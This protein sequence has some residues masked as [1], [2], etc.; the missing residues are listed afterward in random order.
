MTVYHVRHDYHGHKFKF[1]EKFRNLKYFHKFWIVEIAPRDVKVNVK[2]E[3]LG[4]CIPHFSLVRL[5][6]S[7]FKTSKL[8]GV[9]NLSIIRNFH[10]N[11]NFQSFKLVMSV[12]IR[13]LR[14]FGR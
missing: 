1:R 7:L 4:Y 10:F 3:K 2:L 8:I 6:T 5:V 14:K 13:F 12:N 11:G 9:I